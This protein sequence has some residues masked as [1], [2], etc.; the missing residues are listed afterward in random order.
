MSRLGKGLRYGWRQMRR[1]FHLLVGLAFLIFAAIGA[2]L[3]FSEWQ[4]YS[5]NPSNGM[6]RFGTIAGFSLLLVI[7]GLY[8]F[9]KARSVR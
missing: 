1:L 4:A 7:F 6:W 5:Q 8:S 2:S 3:T 9:L